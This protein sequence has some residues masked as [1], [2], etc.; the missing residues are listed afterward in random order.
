[1]DFSFSGIK[2]AVLYYLRGQDMKGE[3]LEL[4]PK[5]VADV[6][7]SFQAAVIDV[8]ATKLLRAAERLGVDRLIVG[9]GVAANSALRRRLTREAEQ[10][11][12][13]LLLPERRYCT[14]NAAMVAGLGFARWRA[15]LFEPLTLEAISHPSD[16]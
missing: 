14:D 3:P 4:P 9:G 5:L 2:T 13:E 8:L 11:G 6:A 1:M 12:Y 16:G 15:G 7:A 10:R